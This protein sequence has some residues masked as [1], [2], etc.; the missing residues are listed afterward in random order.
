M[1]ISCSWNYS[2][3]YS[4]FSFPAAFLLKRLNL[5]MLSPCN[6]SL[7]IILASSCS[8]LGKSY[9]APCVSVH[10]TSLNS[11]TCSSSPQCQLILSTPNHVTIRAVFYLWRLRQKKSLNTSAFSAA[12]VMRVSSPSISG[13]TFFVNLLFQLAFHRI[14]Y[15]HWCS[16]AVLAPAGF[17]SPWFW[18]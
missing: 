12:S 5:K 9:A 8:N 7:T 3:A 10:T 11:L 6:N 14:S 16:S 17:C 4:I 13:S 15:Y 2:H 18:R 1:Y